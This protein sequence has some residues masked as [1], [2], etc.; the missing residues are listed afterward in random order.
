MEIWSI[1][2]RVLTIVCVVVGGTFVFVISSGLL[3]A[4]V[5]W[6]FF[7]LQY[8]LDLAFWML[9]KMLPPLTREEERSHRRAPEPPPPPPVY[10]GCH[11]ETEE[12]A[13]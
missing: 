7:L 5:Y 1:V 9:E 11:V 12:S 10:G 2:Q 3:I 8:P 4:L 13:P 6:V